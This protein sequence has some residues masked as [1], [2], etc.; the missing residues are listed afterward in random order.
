MDEMAKMRASLDQLKVE[1]ELKR[2]ARQKAESEENLTWA[3]YWQAVQVYADYIS[4][5]AEA[6]RKA[7]K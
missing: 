5:K 4:R 3:T 6:A 2:S 7:G 1:Y